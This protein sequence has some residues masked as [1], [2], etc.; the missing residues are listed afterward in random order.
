MKR[1]KDK[2]G[3]VVKNDGDGLKSALNIDNLKH[4]GD[5]CF[6]ADYK[7]RRIAIT[8]APQDDE[9]T[10]VKITGIDYADDE[11]MVRK[12]LITYHMIR[13][14]E[15][16]ETCINMPISAERYNKLASGCTPENE[17]WHEI[18]EALLMLTKLQGYDEL[19]SWSIEL[20][21]E[22]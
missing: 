13:G 11:S 9:E 2:I 17:A 18:R 12:V 21:I 20:T 22:V 15:T 16:A 5:F 3:M 10:L 4:T 8:T 14:S 6:E 7:G 1:L 19:G